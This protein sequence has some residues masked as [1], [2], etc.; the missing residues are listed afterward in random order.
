MLR[1]PNMGSAGLRLLVALGISVCILSAWKATSAARDLLSTPD[2]PVTTA[3]AG[4]PERRWVKLEDAVLD[5]SSR[6]V[7][8]LETLVLANDRSGT[9]PFVVELVGSGTHVCERRARGTLEGAFVGPSSVVFRHERDVFLPSGS[10]LPVFSERKAPRFL[11]RALEWR[12]A[13]FVMSLLLTTLA[14]WAVWT[15][16]ASAPARPAPPKSGRAP[17][18]G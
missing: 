7:R 11:R 15:S 18:R 6:Q 14:I 4:A 12:L 17:D 5:C 8:Q 3:V 10:N 2:E 1:N 9:R 16:E 13:W